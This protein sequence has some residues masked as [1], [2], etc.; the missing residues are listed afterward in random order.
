[1]QI[2]PQNTLENFGKREIDLAIKLLE[3]Y[4]K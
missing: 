2:E 4:K 1:M 3:Q